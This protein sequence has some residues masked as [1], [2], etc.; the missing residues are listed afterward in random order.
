[1]GESKSKRECERK[2]DIIKGEIVILSRRYPRH[3]DNLPIDKKKPQ[4]FVAKSPQLHMK[5][6]GESITTS[7]SFQFVLQTKFRPPFERVCN[8]W[9]DRD[10][11]H[12][13]ESCKVE[14]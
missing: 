3:P 10:K 12:S 7:L 13:S 2:A 9:Y 8:K 11:S 1:M 5:M 6:N 14:W 4:S